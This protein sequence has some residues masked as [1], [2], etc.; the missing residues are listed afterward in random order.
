[1][2]ITGN[3]RW[4]PAQRQVA[5]RASSDGFRR[6]GGLLLIQD[7]QV[8]ELADVPTLARCAAKARLPPRGGS[9]FFAE[10]RTT[11]RQ[12]QS[13]S[14]DA[15]VAEL[16]DAPDLGS[17]GVTRGGSSPSLR[18]TTAWLRPA[19]SLGEAAL[20][21]ADTCLCASG[22]W[23]LVQQDAAL[24]GKLQPARHFRLAATSPS[25]RTKLKSAQTKKRVVL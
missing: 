5:A 7:A 12:K 10:P 22:T 8:A 18:T 2:L 17:G 6:A 16:A 24:F 15:Q 19:A 3:L 11:D 20:S 9:I 13:V 4:L 21:K 14:T 25:L 1:M 23:G